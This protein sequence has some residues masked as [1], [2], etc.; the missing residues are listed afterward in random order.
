MT[1]ESDFDHLNDKIM[2]AFRLFEK[3]QTSYNTK[4]TFLH[5][6]ENITISYKEL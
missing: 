2:T 6:F 5:K 1:N 4:F 3:T